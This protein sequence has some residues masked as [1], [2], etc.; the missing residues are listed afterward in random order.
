MAQRGSSGGEFRR[1]RS[2]SD[3]DPCCR[4]WR[5]PAAPFRNRPAR[6]GSPPT[7]ASE[8]A[9]QE[10]NCTVRSPWVFLA[11]TRFQ[12][13]RVWKLWLAIV[14]GEVQPQDAAAIRET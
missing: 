2:W 1:G 9:P 5:G 12:S 4:H 10:K 13:G 3:T 11:G 7:A 6:I 14:P 8:E